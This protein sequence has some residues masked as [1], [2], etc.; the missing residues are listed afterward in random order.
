MR[1]LTIDA[2]FD[3]PLAPFPH[4][5]HQKSLP[6]H[7]FREA[8]PLPRG[9]CHTGGQGRMVHDVNRE[10]Q[11]FLLGPQGCLKHL[12]AVIGSATNGFPTI[13]P[14]LSHCHGDL[15]LYITRMYGR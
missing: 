9:P 14:S 13:C 11:G 1:F 3:G 10:V 8:L 6:R 12:G 2:M 15:Q 5:S 4:P 7:V